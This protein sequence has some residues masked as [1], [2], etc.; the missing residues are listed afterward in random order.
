[1]F[2]SSI[3]VTNLPFLQKKNTCNKNKQHGSDDEN[4]EDHEQENKRVKMSSV[5]RYVREHTFNSSDSGDKTG[6]NNEN[7]SD[8]INSSSDNMSEDSNW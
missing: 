2:K 4:D 5:E 6:L 8:F 3:F 1:M 7:R